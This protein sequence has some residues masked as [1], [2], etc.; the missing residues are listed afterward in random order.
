MT[1][2]PAP[3]LLLVSSVA[4]DNKSARMRIWRALK[5]S[6][7]GALRDGVYVLPDSA[8][9]RAVFRQQAEDVV[10]TGGTATVL[11]VAADGEAQQRQFVALFDRDPEYAELLKSVEGIRR[12]LA[13]MDEADARRN[14]AGL[15]RDIAALTAIDFF[16]G[17]AREQL[18]HA[19]GDLEA[20]FNAKFSPDE[21]HPAH[22]RIP[23]R[24]RA[25]YRGRA[26][27]TRQ[28]P[29]VDRIASAW[30]IRRFIDPKA[31]FVWLKKPK[32]CPKGALG[33]DFDGAEFSHVGAR[34]TFEV[35]V[36]SFDLEHD[37]AL[38][39]LGQLVHHLDT[40][41]VPVPE[42]AGFAAILAGARSQQVDD[43]K[44]VQA[45]SPVLDA[46]YASYRDTQGE[47]K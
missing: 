41:G 44:L 12:G 9:A 33:F 16:P 3:W 4:G 30:L 35:L 38:V 14:V 17:P 45:M 37:A 27:A 1:I 34:V 24:A 28:R 22:G 29:W 40:G 23:K 43:N 26:W 8:A 46:L 13:R 36:A 6:G 18:E 25:D 20:A 15:R 21:P 10:A 42:A 2:A 47:D 39:R 32:D 7:A 11:A 31:K 5:A 19:F